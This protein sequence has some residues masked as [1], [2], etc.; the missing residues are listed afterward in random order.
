[1]QQTESAA[2]QHTYPKGRLDALT[3]G[4]F[5]VAM[6]LLVLDVR[7][8]DDFTANSNGDLL[9]GL[10]GLEP[11]FL[12]YLLSFLVLGLRW[13]S[14]IEMRHNAEFVDRSYALWSMVYLLL[15]TGIPFSTSVVGRYAEYSP[16]VLA[17]RRQYGSCRSFRLF[18]A[19]AHDRR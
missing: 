9:R 8:P 1:M 11:K 18:Y 17:L 4:I 6:T 19:S 10:I 15:T 5:S 3:D 2:N 7:L 13:L 12:P 16:A 14:S